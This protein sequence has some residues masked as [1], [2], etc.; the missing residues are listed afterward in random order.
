MYEKFLY[1]ISFDIL[2]F[3]TQQVFLL[4]FQFLSNLKSEW[5]VTY[6]FVFQVKSSQ[7][8]NWN[9]PY[10]KSWEVSRSLKVTLK[11]I[12]VLL[13]ILFWKVPLGWRWSCKSVR[14]WKLHPKLWNNFNN[15]PMIWNLWVRV[16]MCCKITDW[17]C[18]MLAIIGC[19]IFCFTVCFPKK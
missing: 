2:N 6:S 1:F 7:C 16:A 14:G 10:H 11:K 8:W 9:L 12:F 17:I 5:R 3:S 15:T 13:W 18:G 4:R 19:W